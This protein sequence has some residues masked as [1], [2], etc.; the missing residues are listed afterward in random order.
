MS[1]L[2]GVRLD[3]WLWAARF[4]KTRSL[5]KAAIEGGKV[6]V[7]GQ[8][9]KPAK[10]VHVGQSLEIRRGEV[11]FTVLIDE[12][13]MQRGPA[14]VARTL[15]TETPESIEA[16]ETDA[17]RRRM[18]RAGLTVPAAKPSKKQR[19]DLQRLKQD[20]AGAEPSDG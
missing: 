7:D 9:A 8:R 20:A 12:L 10:E 19:R 6:H 13:S 14:S 2:A 18:E 16:R 1:T 11:A 3:R 5:A 15:Y 17:A 4:F